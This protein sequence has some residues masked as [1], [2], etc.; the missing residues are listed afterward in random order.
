[1]ISIHEI[2]KI[3]IQS[4]A[5]DV[6]IKAGCA[7]MMRVDGK[8]LTTELPAMTPGQMRELGYEI[9]CSASRDSL[10]QFP[11]SCNDESETQKTETWVKTLDDMR[12][13]DMV[14][15][16]P[17][18]ARIRANLFLQRGTV[19]AAL[20]IIPLHPYSIDEL[21][22]PPVLK[23]FA[24][25]PQGLIILTGPTGSGK[26]TTLAALIEEI[27]RNK[28]SNI[29]TVE[30]PIEY[31]FKDAKSVIHQREVGQ[32]TRTFEAALRSITRQSP[33]VIAI[34]ELRDW[35]SMEVAMMASEIGHLVITTLHTTSAATTIDRIVNSFPQR[36]REQVC[37][38][39]SASLLCITSQR[40]IKRANGP[41]RIPAVEVMTAS[42]TVKKQLEDGDMSDLHACI[43]D[44]AHFGMNSM[45][46]ALEKLYNSH[47]ISYEDAIQFAGNAAELK[48]MLRKK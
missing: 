38:Q 32:D 20:R 9:M 22:L 2:L 27:N 39:L 25:E 40:L 29:F 21:A 41:G 23:R 16:V 35:E 31:I 1:M 45:N 24:M 15:T 26:T 48:Q 11:D 42:P 18:V 5:S 43:R 10:L 3:A 30:D 36:L 34:G 14:F 12:E 47:D 33:D 13:L 19:G 4:K 28:R 7:P 8:M 6:A 17:N 46:Q 44:G 37:R